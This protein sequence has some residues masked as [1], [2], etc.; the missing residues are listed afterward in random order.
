MVPDDRPDAEEHAAAGKPSAVGGFDP[1]E[2]LTDEA[3]SEA[4]QRLQAGI[5]AAFAEAPTGETSWSVPATPAR[6]RPLV[7]DVRLYVCDPNSMQAR[8]MHDS[9]YTFCY[10][11]H[12]GEDYFHRILHGEIYVVSGT[13]MYCLTCALRNGLITSDRLHWQNAHRPRTRSVF[14]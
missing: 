12:P 4:V 7:G 9:A 10:S 3:R 2:E 6:Q 11:K 5:N 1:F 8:V 14:E 13:E